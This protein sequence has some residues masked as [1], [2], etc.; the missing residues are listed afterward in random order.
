MN[1][2]RIRGKHNCHGI[3]WSMRYLNIDVKSYNVRT[4]TTY[5]RMYTK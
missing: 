1:K 4:L 3:Y 2:P 5:M